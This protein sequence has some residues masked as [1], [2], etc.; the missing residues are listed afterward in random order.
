M[1]HW[2]VE[3]YQH[4]L[5]FH[6]RPFVSLTLS[7][8]QTSSGRRSVALC[9][10]SSTSCSPLLLHTL[11][12][13]Y[14]QFTQ[15]VWGGGNPPLP[16]QSWVWCHK[17]APTRLV[18]LLYISLCTCHVVVSSVVVFWSVFSLRFTY[19]TALIAG[20]EQV[21]SVKLHSPPVNILLI[22]TDSSTDEVLLLHLREC[23]QV[24]LSMA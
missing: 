5:P 15:C 10:R 24:S 13:I 14:S 22:C 2:Q 4:L 18:G 1:D 7:F 9:C 8:L 23:L 21:L 3:F 19:L 20:I 12:F 16:P 17:R 6:T 11:F